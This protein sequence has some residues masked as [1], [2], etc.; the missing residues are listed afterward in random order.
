VRTVRAVCDQCGKRI[1][2][3]GPCAGERVLF[4]MTTHGYGMLDGDHRYRADICSPECGLIL[5]KG[6][7]HTI[8]SAK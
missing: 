8:E 6:W 2:A 4:R 1:K 5:V 3:L 7:L